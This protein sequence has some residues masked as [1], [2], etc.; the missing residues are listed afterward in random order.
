LS[1]KLGKGIVECATDQS[2]ETPSKAEKEDFAA[3]EVYNRIAALKQR[4]VSAPKTTK[5][6]QYDPNEPLHLHEKNEPT[7]ADK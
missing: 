5:V 1:R 3:D 2:E 6:F 4:P 7:K